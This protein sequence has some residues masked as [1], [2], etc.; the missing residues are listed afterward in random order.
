MKI[1]QLANQHEAVRICLVSFF[2]RIA[3]V[4]PHSRCQRWSR[5]LE[6][7]MFLSRKRTC[8][9]A[10]HND[11]FSDHTWLQVLEVVQKFLQNDEGMVK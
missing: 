4:N 3:A 5:S 6:V 11:S 7:Q 1:K 8:L 9:C 10:R 2:S